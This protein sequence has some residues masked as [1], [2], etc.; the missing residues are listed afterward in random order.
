MSI[1]MFEEPNIPEDTDDLEDLPVEHEDEPAPA[2]E[3]TA[4][5]DSTDDADA[6]VAAATTGSK[7]R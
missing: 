6:L 7:S 2:A 3:G 5:R 4:N 1:Q